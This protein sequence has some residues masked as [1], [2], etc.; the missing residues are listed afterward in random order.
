MAELQAQLKAATEE[1]AALKA[2][3]EPD[4]TY[5]K[6]QTK[7]HAFTAA[8]DLAIIEALCLG[9][10]RNKVP[11][12]FNIFARFYRIKVP[13]HQIKVS[14]KWVDGKRQSVSRFLL[15]LP[16]ARHM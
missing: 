4:H 10:A 11:T 14:G 2:I 7:S 8:V 12:L 15:Y 6:Q 1:A 3:A 13:G 16:A 5:F 9:V